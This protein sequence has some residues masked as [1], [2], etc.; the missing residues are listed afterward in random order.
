MHVI[1]F[2]PIPNINNA[3]ETRKSLVQISYRPE[4]FSGLIFTVQHC[5]DH[6]QIHF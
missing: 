3:L 1:V 2:C 6:V 4:Y 5:G